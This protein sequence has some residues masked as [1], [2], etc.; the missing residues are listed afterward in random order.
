M[1]TNEGTTAP[2]PYG[3]TR[4][5]TEGRAKTPIHGVLERYAEMLSLADL[6]ARQIRLIIVASA[7]ELERRAQERVAE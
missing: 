3:T 1:K 7:R 5:E 2:N 6:D 4:T